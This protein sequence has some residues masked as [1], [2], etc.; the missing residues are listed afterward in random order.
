MKTKPKS[1]EFVDCMCELQKAKEGDTMAPKTKIYTED[2][3]TGKQETLRFLSEKYNVSIVLV[4]NRYQRGDRGKKLVRPLGPP[5]VEPPKA[6]P[7]RMLVS[8]IKGPT[9]YE[10]ELYS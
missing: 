8:D 4:S 1:L 9:K 7:G 5:R 6:K 3:K 2:Y 10:L